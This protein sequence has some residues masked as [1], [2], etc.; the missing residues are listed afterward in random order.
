LGTVKLKTVP[1]GRVPLK[2]ALVLG[3]VRVRVPSIVAAEATDGSIPA[4]PT[5]ITTVGTAAL[6]IL[7]RIVDTKN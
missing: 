6:A 7:L 1:P 5:A 4:S 2:T 3:L